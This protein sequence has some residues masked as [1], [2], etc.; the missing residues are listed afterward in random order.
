MPSVRSTSRAQFLSVNRGE[1]GLLG[2]Q[3]CTLVSGSNQL[4]GEAA[5]QQG[6]GQ[7]PQQPAPGD[8]AGTHFFPDRQIAFEQKSVCVALGQDPGAVQPAGTA[9]N[10]DSI[11][12]HD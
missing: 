7:N 4:T 5:L 9:S 10:H 1:H 3:R 11:E 12:L 6:L 8:A 2:V